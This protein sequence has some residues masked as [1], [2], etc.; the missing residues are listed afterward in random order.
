M[1]VKSTQKLKPKFNILTTPGRIAK[2]AHERAAMEEKEKHTKIPEKTTPPPQQTDTLTSSLEKKKRKIQILPPPHELA[3]EADLEALTKEAKGGS[4]KKA[5]LTTRE[6]LAESAAIRARGSKRKQQVVHDGV[7]LK[8]VESGGGE[9]KAKGKKAAGEKPKNLMDFMRDLKEMPATAAETTGP[10]EKKTSRGGAGRA[11]A[12]KESVLVR[13]TGRTRRLK[14]KADGRQSILFQNE[15]QDDTY[16]SSLLMTL[17]LEIRQRIWRLVVVET[18]FF[19]YPAISPEQPDLAMT[20]RQIRGEV[21]PLFYGENTF[22]VE[23]PIETVRNSTSGRVSLGPARKWVAALEEGEHVG[24]IRKWVLSLML[25]AR[26][27]AGAGMPRLKSGGEVLISLQYPKS[28]TKDHQH[29]ELEIHRQGTCLLPSHDKYRQCVRMCYPL[30][31]D[32]AMAAAFLVEKDNRGKQVIHFAA[33]IKRKVHELAE[34]LCMETAEVMVVEDD[35][36]KQRNNER[37]R[38]K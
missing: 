14:A 26:E 36:E 24:T 3:A 17:P 35:R 38:R 27:V 34:C 30:W 7:G 19:V 2:A 1:P 32:D 29:P 21:L 8:V 25:P 23:V 22:A 37:V 16:L 15:L 4:K 18:Q 9:K 11:K 6:K 5:P 31:L 12:V 13:P 33:S 10:M 20:S 28:G